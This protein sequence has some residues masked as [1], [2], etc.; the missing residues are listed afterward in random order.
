M[1][2]EDAEALAETHAL[3][4]QVLKPEE[5]RLLQRIAFEGKSYLDTAAE[6]GCSLWACQK[7]MQRVRQKLRAALARQNQQAAPPPAPEERREPQDGSKPP[8]KA[9]D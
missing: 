6:L 1:A 5:L 2:L 7:R 4:R 9:R 8:K 3:L